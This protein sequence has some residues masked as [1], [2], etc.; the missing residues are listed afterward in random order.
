MQA[1]EV[2]VRLASNELAINVRVS[3]L[4]CE[5]CASPLL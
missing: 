1:A 2:E 5:A 4:A 3:E